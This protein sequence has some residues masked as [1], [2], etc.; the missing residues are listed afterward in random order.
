[1]GH[2]VAEAINRQMAH[3]AYHIGQ[4]VFIGKMVKGE[5]WKSLTIPRGKSAEYNATKFSEEKR[6]AHFT[7]VL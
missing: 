7:K 6:K 4:I 5:D 3:Y 1:M 2:T